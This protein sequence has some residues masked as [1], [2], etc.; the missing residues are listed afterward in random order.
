VLLPGDHFGITAASADT[1]DSFEVFQFTLS[2][3]DAVTSHDSPPP[4]HE[5][6]QSPPPPAAAQRAGE[7]QQ[8]Q[9]QHQ[10]STG[11]YQTGQHPDLLSVQGQINGIS[12]HLT[13]IDQKLER[14][15]FEVAHQVHRVEEL[16]QKTSTKED[17]GKIEHQMSR[18]ELMLRTVQND[19]K[20]RDYSQQFVKLQEMVHRSHGHLYDHFQDTSHSMSSPPFPI[21]LF[22][23]FSNDKTRTFVRS[24]TD[25]ILCLPG[26]SM[27]GRTGGVV[28]ALQATTGAD[29]E[30]VSLSSLQ[31]VALP[32]ASLS[33]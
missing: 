31:V 19:L 15:L 28:R 8:D 21:S 33:I 26:A 32:F 12:L 13:S 2:T 24:P 17:T 10:Q 5:Q 1:P 4:H 14:I 29:P 7:H 9:Q 23:S 30:E 3:P 27:P 20:E 25:G 18:V 16:L 11:E 22:P 6:Q